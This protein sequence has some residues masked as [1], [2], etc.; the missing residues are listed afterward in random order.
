MATT[1]PIEHYVGPIPQGA[2]VDHLC[3]TEACTEGRL[4]K[5]RRCWNPEHLAAVSFAENCARGNA[6]GETT[7]RT[8]ICKRGH[9]LALVGVYT[10]LRASGTEYRRCRACETERRRRRALGLA[11]ADF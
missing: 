11:G 7:R 5:H 3:H 6:P 2:V 4:C 9:E 10:G 1:T 8:G